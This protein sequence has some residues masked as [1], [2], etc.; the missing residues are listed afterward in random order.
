MSTGALESKHTILLAIEG[1]NSNIVIGVPHHAPAGVAKLRCGR[2]SDENTGFLGSYI[3]R[4]IE[5]CCVIA[6]NYTA[7]VNK[8]LNNEFARQLLSWN[9]K[10]YVEIHGHARRRTETD[11][12]VSCG[13][14]EKNEYSVNLAKRLHEECQRHDNLRALTICGDFGKILFKGKTVKTIQSQAWIGFLI[15]LAPRLRYTKGQQGGKPPS[16]GFDFCDCLIEQ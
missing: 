16:M 1:S 5:C 3:A 15:E 6:C 13:S 10:V 4:R 2:A 12:E 11:V 9:P 14:L 8:T 7:D